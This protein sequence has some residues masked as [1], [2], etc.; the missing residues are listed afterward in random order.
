[1]C[2]SV[3]ECDTKDSTCKI[4][5][6]S[7]SARCAGGEVDSSL[8]CVLHATHTRQD[9]AIFSY[10]NCVTFGVCEV[11]ICEKRDL[12]VGLDACS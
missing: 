11:G 10:V 5:S 9:F 2:C 12:V 4:G 6:E 8:P 3:L 1:M 7:A